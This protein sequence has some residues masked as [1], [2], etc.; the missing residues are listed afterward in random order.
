M[1]NNSCDENTMKGNSSLEQ[2]AHQLNCAIKFPQYV[3]F[4]QLGG[5]SQLFI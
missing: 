2:T 1:E 4:G 3:Q 5:D